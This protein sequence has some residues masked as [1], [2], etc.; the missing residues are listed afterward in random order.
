MNSKKVTIYARYTSDDKLVKVTQESNDINV[1]DTTTG[2]QVASYK[3]YQ[4]KPYRK[5]N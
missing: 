5:E 1:I 3:G 4:E 2:K